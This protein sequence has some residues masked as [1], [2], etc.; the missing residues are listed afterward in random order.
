MDLPGYRLHAL[1]GNFSGF[2]VV[3]VDGNWRFVFRL[4]ESH[5]YDVDNMYYHQGE[6]VFG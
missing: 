1:C 4:V 2:N 5:A 3:S 6:I